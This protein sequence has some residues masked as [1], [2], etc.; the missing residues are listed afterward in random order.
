MHLKK[1]FIILAASFV[2]FATQVQAQV[3][4]IAQARLRDTGTTVTVRGIVTNGTEIGQTIRAL[5]DTTAG[6]TA[7]YTV[8]ATPSFAAVKRGDSLEITGKLKSFNALLE[9]D[10]IVSFRVINSNNPLP[11][12]LSITAA[13]L[14][15]ANESRLVKLTNGLFSGQGTPTFVGNTT[16]NCTFGGIVVPVRIQT[17]SALTGK[18]I[19][20]T[21]IN[22]TGLV[23][24]FKGV[25]QLLPRDSADIEFQGIAI[26]STVKTTTLTTTGATL[27]WETNQLGT[28]EIRYGLTTA[29][30][31][32]AVGT[33]GVSSHS[34]PLSNLTPATIYYIRV[35]S[36]GNGT[37]DSSRI[38]SIITASLSS[39]E[40]R[41]YFNHAVDTTYK[42]NG[43]APLATTGSRCESEIS[44]FIA[45]AK[46]T[47]DVAMYSNSST[48]I[49]TALKQAAARG[50]R[51]RYIAD[52][53]ALNSAFGDTATLG[54]K[55]I[56]KPTTDLMHNKFMIIDVDSINTSW[57]MSGAMNWSI[58]QLYTDYN[59]AVFIQDQSLA[60][61]YRVEFEEMWG[62]S[63]A[64]PNTTLGK[65]G[66]NKADNTPKLVK[67]AG[68]NVE[69][70]FSPT[71][72]TSLAIA[73]ALNTAD[74]DLEFSLLIFT[75]FDLGTAVYNAKRRGADVRGLVDQD[76]TSTSSAQINYLQR[77]GV[78]VKL[79]R[80]DYIFHH[81]YAIIDGKPA[82]ALS[83]PQVLTGSH[84][85]TNTA[86]GKNDEN[87]L[88][89]HDPSVANIFLQEFEARWKEQGVATKEVNIDGFAATVSPN[90]AKDFINVSIKNDVTRDVSM[91]IVNIN[92]QPIE[93]AIFRNVLGETTKSIP[94]S[95]LA[96]GMYFV[97]FNVG[98]QY[99]TKQIQVVR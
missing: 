30:G 95:N 61:T 86:E 12:P 27:S 74:V 62:S 75:Y 96:S 22:L 84:N 34:I 98:G 33:A 13:G 89:I 66:A 41:I 5:Q 44:A 7:F 55:L 48:S 93:T 23:S 24:D 29:L 60:K 2:G 63:T 26:T 59:N 49:V 11:T 31:S 21:P 53:S 40:T 88:I 73:N 18:V 45:R 10:P 72:E 52:K 3:I 15:E 68:K 82:G 69:V 46:S 6:L 91:T 14:N 77:N 35:V 4:S 25:Y 85:W 57:V 51:V 37:K 94:L 42:T 16:Y 76:T 70:Y 19:P 20:T 64:T 90:P 38:F 71:D 97:V 79:F 54:F 28:T 65:F 67:V 80:S 1:N 17:G 36:Q 32:S 99:L 81:K 92:G 9:I 39:G 43:S 78:N 58:G 50:V 47:I 8:A 83:D 87:L 56:K